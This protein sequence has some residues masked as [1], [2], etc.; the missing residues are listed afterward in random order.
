MNVAYTVILQHYNITT[1]GNGAWFAGGGF[2]SDN[3]RNSFIRW[4]ISGYGNGW[5][6]NDFFVPNTDSSVLEMNNVVKWKYI[7]P[8]TFGTTTMYINSTQANLVITNGDGVLSNGNEIY[9]IGWA[10]V[11]E[12]RRLEQLVNQMCLMNTWMASFIIFTYSILHRTVIDGYLKKVLI[13]QLSRNA[14]LLQV[15]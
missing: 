6:G 13:L 5:F 8:T 9:R 1:D 11:S 14:S 10:G 3:Q 12:V 4:Q 7:G 2:Y 15:F